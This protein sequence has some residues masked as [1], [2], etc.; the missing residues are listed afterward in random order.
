MAEL[1]L[2]DIYGPVQEDLARVEDKLRSLSRVDPPELAM[3]LDYSLPSSG[4]RLR[5]I[6]TLLSGQF[7]DYNLGLL[8]PMAAA[9]ELLHTATLIHDDA[10]DNSV[11]RRGR[12]TVFKVWG[13]EKAV[14]LGDYLFAEAGALTAITN[15]LRV[16]KLFA[17][18]L[19]TISTGE[20]NQAFNSFNLS[21][22]REEYFLRVARKTASL[23]AMSTESGSALSGAPEKSVQILIDYGYNLGVAFQVVDDILDFVSTEEE[24]GKP[25]GSDLGQGTLTL[26]AM[27]LLERYPENNPVRV[28]FEKR[29][30]DRAS[31]EKAIQMVRDSTII[32]DCYKVASE[33]IARARRDLHLLPDRPAR[34]SF[35]NIAEYVLSRKK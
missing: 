16:I 5:P 7:Y 24:M 17:Q 27:L 13:A 32:D 8:L 35:L 20:L 18:T 31:I 33:Y 28:I 29:V 11:T 21:Q 12:P 10:I 9:V 2:S 14:L 19:K 23:F 15:N 4:K 6:L 22:G 25:V 34:Q 1:K 26:P 3:L 30:A